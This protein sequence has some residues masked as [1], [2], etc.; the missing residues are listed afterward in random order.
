MIGAAIGS[1]L[2]YGGCDVGLGAGMALSA[3]AGLAPQWIIATL[4]FALVSVFIAGGAGVGG[5]LKGAAQK[6]S[7][8]GGNG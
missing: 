5:A 6:D 2:L 7:I 1:A 8:T 3:G 4:G